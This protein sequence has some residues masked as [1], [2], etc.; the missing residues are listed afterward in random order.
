VSAAD[1]AR[2]DMP[3]SG[4]GRCLC[5]DVRFRWEGPALWAVH[6][7]CESCRR[8]CSAGFTSFFGVADADWSW[9][10]APPRLYESSPGVRR[11]FCPRC[12]AQMAFQAD[13]YPGETHF[14]AASM[15]NPEAYA[16]TA[17]VHAD[18][19]LCWVRLADDLP[20]KEGSP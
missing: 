1:F 12:G 13:R 3:A 7:H 5:G 15:E 8:A 16:P 14:Y 17:H 9:T 10:G 4:A 20:R 2:P 18:E 19:R 11:W 6:C